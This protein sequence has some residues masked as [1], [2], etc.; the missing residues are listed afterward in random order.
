MDRPDFKQ[1]P[2]EDYRQLRMITILAFLLAVALLLPHGIIAETALPAI[3]IA[4]MFF[5]AAMGGL[6]FTGVLR[7]PKTKASMDLMLAAFIFSI[8]VPRCVFFS[9]LVVRERRTDCVSFSAVSC[10]CEIMA[11]TKVPPGLCSA[12]TERP[13]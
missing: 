1:R 7:S 3:G 10:P 11:G 6:S 13:R 9:F 8:M 2:G 12:L 4:P 5:S